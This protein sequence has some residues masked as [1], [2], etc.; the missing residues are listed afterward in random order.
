MPSITASY[1]CEMCLILPGGMHSDHS[2]GWSPPL[3]LCLER[4]GRWN[5]PRKSSRSI[6]ASRR[7]TAA[8]RQLIIINY[9]NDSMNVAPCIMC[10]TLVYLIAEAELTYLRQ[11]Y[12]AWLFDS[13]IN[14]MYMT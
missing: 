8:D 5:D 13:N 12:Q 6:A 4:C 11:L 10:Y 2:R 1:N 14:T 9:E 7:A 3:P